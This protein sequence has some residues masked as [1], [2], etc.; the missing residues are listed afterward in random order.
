MLLA[1]EVD[2]YLERLADKRFPCDCPECCLKRRMRLATE[3]EM[4]YGKR[5]MQ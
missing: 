5:V 4:K 1:N 3:L 2:L